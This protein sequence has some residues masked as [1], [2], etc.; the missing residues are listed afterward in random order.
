MRTLR[1]RHLSILAGLAVASCLSSSPGGPRTLGGGPTDG[2]A[3]PAQDAAPPPP[4]AG[5]PPPVDAAA[6]FDAAPT[7]DAAAPVAALTS[8]TVSG[9][10]F[11]PAFSPTTYDYA[12]PCKAGPNAATITATAAP[13]VTVSLVRPATA[14]IAPSIGVELIE[15]DLAV[16]EAT[17]TD[18]SKA[19]YYLRCLPHD[20][21]TLVPL[22][23]ASTTPGWYLLGNTI[24]GQGDAGYAMVLDNNGTP[25]W[26]R[27]TS[28]GAGYVTAVNQDTIAWMAVQ[29]G[30]FGTDPS[31][32]FDILNLDTGASQTVQAVTS[33]T[34]EHELTPMANGDYLIISYPLTTGIDM[35]SKGITNTTTIA[36]CQIQEI[37]PTGT[38]AWSW[39]GSDHIDTVTESTELSQGTVNGQ[40]TVDPFHCN[41]IDVTPTGDLL[42]SAR[43]T[44]A[45]F[46]I[47][48]ATGTIAWK[49]GGIPSS[50]DGATIIQLQG[51]T[52]GS[53][54]HQHD[55]RLLANGDITLFDD[56]TT[57]FDSQSPPPGSARGMEISFDVTHGTASVVWQYATTA[58]SNAMGSCRRYSDGTSVIGWGF[59]P[60]GAPTPAM[61]EVDGQGNVLF[62]VGFGSLDFAYRVVKVPT[63]TFEIGDLR[64]TAG[65]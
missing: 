29:P 48:K 45:V 62:E 3:P 19:D 34:D 7:V 11:T 21:P 58:A 23:H 8:L 5:A 6:P 55:A 20:F 1:L 13:G 54:Y 46:L 39:L 64:N 28:I 31:G 24:L 4:D 32:H 63:S 41:S 52:E 56:H 35:S 38:L 9:L 49:L 15:N 36:D 43:Q 33:P 17:S 42:V 47:T 59:I 25:I 26:Y 18:G 61:S 30:R 44:D 51:D 2:G 12:A 57:Q 14:P 50:K 10:T 27:S 65:E 40:P 37:T 60:T 16:V 53:F 22:R